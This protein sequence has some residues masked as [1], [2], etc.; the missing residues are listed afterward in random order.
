MYSFLEIEKMKRIVY[1]MLLLLLSL[2]GK[3]QVQVEQ[4]IDSVG[5]FIGQQAHM[6]V[7]VTARKGAHVQFPDFVNL[8]QYIVPGV[9][10]L[11]WKGDTAD[12][13]DGMLKIT[14]TYTL[15]SFD[16]ALYSIP[17]MQVKVDGK[18]YKGTKVALKVITVEVDTLH[19]NQFFP[20]K[21]V[22]DNP[23]SWD[24]WKRAI[25]LGVLVLVLM[26]VALYL[27]TRLKKNKPIMVRIRV[28][29]RVLPHLKALSAIDKIKAEHMQSSEDQKAYY[30]R[31][32][33]TL[34][35]YIVERFGFNAMEMT[36]S[37]IIEHLRASGDPTMIGELRELFR[38]ADLVK[39]AKYSTLLGENDMNLVNAVSFIDQ[40]K[41]EGQPTEERI[42]PKL[43]DN[44][45]K[46]QANRFI[47]KVLLAIISFYIVA[48]L[49]YIVYYVSTL[50][51]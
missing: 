28:V 10:V 32:T 34:R 40:T 29:K 2:G 36:S 22:Q 5:M 45:K 35:Q 37:E 9:E 19:P 46:M 20:P 1:T 23:F 38:T 13:G 48:L 33:D 3:A 42:V 47:I 17:S 50:L 18:A 15:T 21:D 51:I 49:I 43:S 8:P 24:D 31:L 6:S 7:G 30:T 14:R 12:A 16:E 39:F 26:A 25:W 11:A 44:D 41:K 4:K 27:W